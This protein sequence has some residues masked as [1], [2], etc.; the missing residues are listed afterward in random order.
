MAPR[1]EMRDGDVHNVDCTR[2]KD[3]SIRSVGSWR[4]DGDDGCEKTAN[5]LETSDESVSGTSGWSGEELW[6]VSEQHTIYRS[7][8]FIAVV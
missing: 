4:V 8:D 6:S 1:D 7:E 2:G 5:T 3:G